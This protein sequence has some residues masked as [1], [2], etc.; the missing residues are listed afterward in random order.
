M[1]ALED[2]WR[3][4]LDDVDAALVDEYQ[5]GFPVVERPF[6]VVGDALGIDETEALDRVRDLRER[7][8]F[9]RFGAVLN[10]PSSA[11]RRSQPSPHPR[12]DSTRSPR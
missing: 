7:G 5:S 11:A 3:A 12:T 9:R 1:S 6:R 8:I 4:D 10:P 2:D